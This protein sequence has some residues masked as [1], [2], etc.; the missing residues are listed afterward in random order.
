MGENKRMGDYALRHVG[1]GAETNVYT[2]RNRKKSQGPK[3]L[4]V[5]D[6]A[7]GPE[8]S[9]QPERVLSYNDVGG[10][11]DE[12]KAELQIRYRALRSEYGDVIA[13]SR[14]IKNPDHPDLNLLAQEYVELADPAR[15]SEYY[16]VDIEDEAV[17]TKITSFIHTLKKNIQQLKAGEPAVVVDLN[18]DNLV[19]NK[20]LNRLVYIDLDVSYEFMLMDDVIL[21]IAKIEMLGG[22]KSESLRRDEFYI[23]VLAKYPEFATIDDEHD[24]YTALKECEQDLIGDAFEQ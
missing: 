19:F 3:R 16:P 11:D 6:F 4:V 20:E 1:Q 10:F 21:N 12:F 22:A 14:F 9:G 8:K 17:K 7:L 24:F 18:G 13:R 2:A 23:P 5:K 15:V